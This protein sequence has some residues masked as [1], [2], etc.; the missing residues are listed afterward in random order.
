MPGGVPSGVPQTSGA[1]LNLPDLVSGGIARALTLVRSRYEGNEDP[2]Y[3]LPFHCVVHTVGL[4][5]RTGALLRAMGASEDEFHL[6]LLAAAFHDTVQN[7]APL[8]T[9]DGRVLRKGFTGHNEADSAAEAVAWMCRAGVFREEHYDLVSR[10]ILATIPVWDALH[11]TVSQPQLTHAAPLVV[12]AVALADLG[13]AGMD[14][15]PFL[16]TGDQLFR[17][18][19]LDIDAALR[20]CSTRADLSEVVLE[21]YKARMLTWSRSSHRKLVSAF[22]IMAASGCLTS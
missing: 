6:G 18:E 13:I 8:T 5:R 17:E 12:R 7:W 16:E 1:T 10:A 19:N 21:G 20:R 11:Q 4:L 15:L 3:N 9:P 2:A 22:V 14:G